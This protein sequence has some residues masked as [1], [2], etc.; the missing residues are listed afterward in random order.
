M[1]RWNEKLKEH[2]IHNTLNQALS[3]IN[4]KPNDADSAFQSEQRRLKKLINFFKSTIN[5]L[6]GELI[7]FDILDQLNS[8]IRN[9]DIWVHFSSFHSRKEEQHLIDVNDKLNEV[10]LKF[11]QLLV[12]A[13]KAKLSNPLKDLEE[14]FDNFTETIASKKT[15]LEDDINEQSTLLERQNEKLDQLSQNLDSSKKEINELLAT[16]QKQ[17]SDSENIRTTEF[18]STQQSKNNEFSNWKKTVEEEANIKIKTLIETST[19]NLNNSQSAF[20]EKISN[21]L[22][23][24]SQKHNDILEL[25]GLVAGDSVGAGYSKSAKDE[26]KQADIWRFITIAFIAL[27]VGWIFYS[28]KLNSVTGFNGEVIW[29]EIL[30]VFSLTGVL[31]FAASY[32]AKQSKSHRDNEIQARK[33]ALEIKAI[34]PFISSLDEKEQKE[35]KNKFSDRLFAQQP[36]MMEK[37][38]SIINE[39]AF[40][41]LIKGITDIL[42]A[43]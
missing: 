38:N 43:K 37:E 16:W 19:D 35:L 15:I 25:H 33:F 39:K 17:H 12:F 1:S 36:N 31:L 27:T 9:Q 18:N 29:V 11:S 2:P 28:Y 20:D 4:N 41:I 42:R 10:I 8:A 26:K 34:D 22:N 24:A 14:S 40:N 23:D 6:D 5:K 21:I 13:E 7:S 32:S 3:L 30:R